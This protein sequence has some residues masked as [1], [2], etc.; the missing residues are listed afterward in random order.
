M[1]YTINGTQYW[2]RNGICCSWTKEGGR[3]VISSEEYLNAIGKKS[4]EVKVNEAAKDLKDEISSGKISMNP[5]TKDP[6]SKV[7]ILYQEVNKND[8]IVN[9]KKVVT[10][11][12]LEKVIS[13]MEAKDNFVK[14]LATSDVI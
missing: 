1:T 10:Y 2:R 4:D 14:I 11:G 8:R 3:K 7:E 5:E 12:N 13:N 6:K 9:K